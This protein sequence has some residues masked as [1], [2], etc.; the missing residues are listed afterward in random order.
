LFDGPLEGE[1]EWA[2]AQATAQA[3]PAFF[4]GLKG[5]DRAAELMEGHMLAVAVEVVLV[6]DYWHTKC[7]MFGCG[8]NGHLVKLGEDC[9][10]YLQCTKHTQHGQ[11]LGA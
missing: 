11:E 3:A 2:I 4:P 9:A 6:A 7:K 5:L 10:G 8:D 1:Q